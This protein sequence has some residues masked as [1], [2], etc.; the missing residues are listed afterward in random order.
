MSF[1]HDREEDS[2][3]TVHINLDGEIVVLS[4]NRDYAKRYVNRL[5]LECPPAF[6]STDELKILEE[7]TDDP[8]ICAMFLGMLSGALGWDTVNTIPPAIRTSLEEAEKALSIVNYHSCVV[9]CRRTIEALLRFAFPRLLGNP[10]VDNKGRPLTLDAMIQQFG[11][12]KPL[13][14]PNHL[15]HVLDSIRSIGN[16]PGAHATE[17]EGYKFSKHDAEFTLS[18]VFY[19]IEQYFSKIDKEVTQYYTLTI[20]LS[21]E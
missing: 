6:H 1:C 11:K 21:E 19:F 12:Q 7:W 3:I 17:I 20:N 2:F 13:P 4:N 10:A 16:V 9:M 15:L 5:F 14:I 8:R 18:S